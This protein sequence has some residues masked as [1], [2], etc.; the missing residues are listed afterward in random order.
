MRPAAAAAA[1]GCAELPLPSV[2][3]AAAAAAAS[4]ARAG[5]LKL[6]MSCWL[7]LLP[8]KLMTELALLLR[9]RTSYKASC[10][11]HYSSSDK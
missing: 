5:R 2:G 9:R 3:A 1:A 11:S 7:A 6:A 8:P 4:S 10:R